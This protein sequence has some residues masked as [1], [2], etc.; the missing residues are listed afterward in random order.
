MNAGRD[1]AMRV[2]IIGGG[3]AG[4]EALIG[5][6]DLAGDRVAITLV[7]PDPEFTYKPMTVEEP[8]SPTPAERHELAPIAAEFDARFVQAALTSMRPGEHL[9]ELSDASALTYDASIVCIGARQRAAFERAAALRVAGE[10]LPIN[11]LLRAAAAHDS[12]RIAFVV[13]PGVSWPL[14]I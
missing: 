2:L 11:D 5:L 10:P 9:A 3:I 4:L 8:F 7:A 6:S 14:P 12:R 1:D 13:P